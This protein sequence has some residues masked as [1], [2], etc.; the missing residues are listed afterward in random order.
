MPFAV[1]QLAKLVSMQ[2]L[3][4]VQQAVPAPLFAFSFESLLQMDPRPKNI[5]PRSSQVSG[6][7]DS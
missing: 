1:M 4:K 3:V 7:T 5:P 6:E 2:P